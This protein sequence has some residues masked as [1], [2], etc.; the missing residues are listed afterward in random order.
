MTEHHNTLLVTGKGQAKEGEGHDVVLP[1]VSYELLI[2]ASAS[3]K[4]KVEPNQVTVRGDATCGL[5]SGTESEE[6]LCESLSTNPA[7]GF[8]VSDDCGLNY[9]ALGPDV[10]AACRRPHREMEGCLFSITAGGVKLLIDPTLDAPVKQG[11]QSIESV[12][13]TNNLTAPGPPGAVDKGERQE[14]GQKLLLS[15]AGS[16]D[17]SAF[18]A[19]IEN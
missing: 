15:T 6:S 16:N 2:I 7:Q 1:H 13:A 14:R 3:A 8:T 9:Q 11:Q 10:P 12:I 17:A 18:G 4:L 5:R 19:A